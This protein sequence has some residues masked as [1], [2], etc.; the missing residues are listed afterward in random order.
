MTQTEDEDEGRDGQ[1]EG[2]RNRDNGG[3]LFV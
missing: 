1:Y 3:D 2:R